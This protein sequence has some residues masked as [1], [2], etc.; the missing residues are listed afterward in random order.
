M[1][2]IQS[3]L[4]PPQERPTAVSLGLCFLYLL[5]RFLITAVRVVGSGLVILLF[6][7]TEVYLLGTLLKEQTLSESDSMA[8]CKDGVIS[9]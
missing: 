9:G 4:S 2:C 6:S 7:A 1:V 3:S 5:Q 8:I